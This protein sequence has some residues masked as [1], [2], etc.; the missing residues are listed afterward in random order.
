MALVFA[1]STHALVAHLFDAQG[2]DE[3]DTRKA[4]CGFACHVSQL[5]QV[6]SLSGALPCELCIRDLPDD[7]LAASREVDTEQF[8]ADDTD[9][10]ETYA[11]GL[12]G[13]FI[14]HRVPAR[15]QLHTYEGRDVV[16][17]ECGCIAFLSFGAPP[18]RYRLCSDCTPNEHEV[19]L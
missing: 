10:S 17:A 18:D 4:L 8:P 12:R 15:P 16:V 5:D 9:S 14:A 1:R 13:E 11:V 2:Q 3:T 7:V 19:S 6:P